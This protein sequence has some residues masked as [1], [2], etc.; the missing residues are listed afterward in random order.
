MPGE[1]AGARQ[2]LLLCRSL[3][4]LERRVLRPLSVAARHYGLP[5]PVTNAVD[6][7]MIQVEPM[8]ER[9]VMGHLVVTNARCTGYDHMQTEL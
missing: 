6:Q 5:T 3:M 9:C 1:P 7:A 8:T 2:P 4:A